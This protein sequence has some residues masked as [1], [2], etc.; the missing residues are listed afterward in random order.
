M[1]YT[2]ASAT[3]VLNKEGKRMTT[4]LEYATQIIKENA[5]TSDTACRK[6]LA[7]A[8]GEP[9]NSPNTAPIA[10]ADICILIDPLAMHVLNASIGMSGSI[11]A[12]GLDEL[13]AM[14]HH[15]Q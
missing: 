4:A 14:E 6:R 5:E 12:N 7:A 15:T 10:C 13:C 8:T 9:N 11:P 3:T 2:V 1:K